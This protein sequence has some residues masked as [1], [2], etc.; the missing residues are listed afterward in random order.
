MKQLEVSLLESSSRPKREVNLPVGHFPSMERDLRQEKRTELSG[1]G[2][3]AF[4]LEKTRVQAV[5]D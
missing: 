1:N 3:L 4:Q 5:E 2:F